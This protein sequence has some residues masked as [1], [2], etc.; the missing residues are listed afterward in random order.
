MTPADEL[1]TKS[2]FGEASSSIGLGGNPGA[3]RNASIN[4]HRAAGATGVFPRT[5][6]KR[7]FAKATSYQKHDAH[8]FDCNSETLGQ[9]SITNLPHTKSFLTKAWKTSVAGPAACP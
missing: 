2:G 4:M 9:C 6:E 3:T 7:N 1:S 5:E 8:A